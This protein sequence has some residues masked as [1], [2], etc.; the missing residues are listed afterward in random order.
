MVK[1][2]TSILEALYEG[3]SVNLLLFCEIET[4][5]KVNKLFFYCWLLERVISGNLISVVLEIIW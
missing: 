4:L 5:F 2:F 1:L 3:I